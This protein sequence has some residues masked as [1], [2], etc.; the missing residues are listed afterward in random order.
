ML[1]VTREPHPCTH[2]PRFLTT[3]PGH[4]SATLTV[5]LD[6]IARR[7]GTPAAMLRTTAAHLAR[8]MG[9]SV[10]NLKLDTT[11]PA[12]PGFAAHLGRKAQK[13]GSPLTYNSVQSKLNHAR[14]LLALARKS[15]WKLMPILAELAWQS[16]LGT[17]QTA[18][19]PKGCPGLTRF[20]IAP[21]RTPFEFNDADLGAFVGFKTD[22][23]RKPKYARWVARTFRKFVLEAGLTSRFPRLSRRRSDYFF[24]NSVGKM[25]EPLRSVVRASVDSKLRPT[26]RRLPCPTRNSN[27]RLRRGVKIRAASTRALE[28]TISVLRVRGRGDEPRSQ[29]ASHFARSCDRGN[30][31]G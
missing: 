3:I 7:P 12:L 14:I 25:P 9:A 22:T 10:A 27:S 1:D 8:Y 26:S 4:P 2:F 11:H 16:A 21:G 24:G 15:G 13:N 19:L 23:G 6:R 17:I 18:Q 5:L 30:H 29:G 20:V 31:R 28:G